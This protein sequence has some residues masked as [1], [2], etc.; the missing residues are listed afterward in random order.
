V[1]EA[2]PKV[3]GFIMDTW[4]YPLE[5]IGALGPDKGQ[6]GPFL[7]L[8][9]GYEGDV[10]DGF[11][12]VRSDT[13][14]VNVTVRGYVVEGRPEPAVEQIK[15]MRIYPLAQKNLFFHGDD[16]DTISYFELLAKVAHEDVSREK[17]RAMWGLA[18]SIGIAKDRPFEPDERMTGILARA[19]KLGA[20][21]AA[22]ESCAS[23]Y[24]AKHTWE[25]TQWEEIFHTPH[26]TLE[27]PDYLEIDARVAIYYQAMGA[28]KA[29]LL[30]VVGAGSKY[31]ASFRDGSGAWLMGD[32]AYHLRVPADVPVA[33][34]W[35]VTVYDAV[36]RSM[37]DNA[38]GVSGRDSYDGLVTNHDG[39][40]DLYFGPEAPPGHESNWVQTNPGVGFFVYF[41]WYG[42]TQPYFDKTWRL[43]DIQRLTT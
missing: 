6:G 25:G 24:P 30:S 17:D 38:Q 7:I 34:F 21:M 41:R 42:P 2:P 28:A 32:A 13:N 4:Q 40:V 16:L 36:T 5:D 10:P 19:A 1:I 27:S 37:I 43:L 9:P 18:A 12:V 39:S 31:S 35:S 23:R 20:A 26:A 11:F 33:D 14:F 15:R 3:L 22:A 29:A 8:P